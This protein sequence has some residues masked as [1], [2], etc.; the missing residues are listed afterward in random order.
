MAYSG[1]YNYFPSQVVSD[2]EKLRYKVKRGDY[3]GSIAN[4]YNCKIKDIKTW[5]D[6]K[7]DQ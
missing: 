2:I 5:N 7:T 3:L 1:T 4:Q 6:L